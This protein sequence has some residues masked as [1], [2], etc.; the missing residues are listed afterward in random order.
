MAKRGGSRRRENVDKRRSG[1]RRRSG[2]D[3]FV[4]VET[5]EKG[6]IIHAFSEKNCPGLLVSI[7][8][9]F[10]ELDLELSDATVSCSDCFRLEAVSDVANGGLPY[11]GSSP[12]LELSSFDSVTETVGCIHLTDI[13]HTKL[14]GVQPVTPA[15]RVSVPHHCSEDRL[16][17][18]RLIRN[19]EWCD[20]ELSHC[21]LVCDLEV[22]RKRHYRGTTL[23]IDNCYLSY[24]RDTLKA[25]DSREWD[26]NYKKVKDLVVNGQWNDV[27]LA[28]LFT[29]DI[30]EHIKQKLF[31]GP[32]ISQSPSLP[33]L[34]RYEATVKV[35][36]LLMVDMATKNHTRPSCARVKIEIDLITKLPHRVKINEKD[37]ITGELKSKWIQ[38][39]YDHK[40]KYCNECCLQGHDKE[41]CWNI[42]H[43][44]YAKSQEQRHEKDR[45]NEDEKRPKEMDR[46]AT[47]DSNKYQWLQ[48]R[49]KYRRDRF[50]HI[51]ERN[52]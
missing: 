15:G 23:K 31:A 34:Q 48:R 2:H 41:S 26:D 10:E 45:T 33:Q 19:T 43:E 20:G 7:L 30:V 32:S 22:W 38:I 12:F 44:I 11:S 35:G 37:D 21:H 16:N 9:A 52:G 3:G 51:L 39:Q 4:T 25:Q 5:L 50:G 40:P 46:S 1:G 14:T 28:E 6:F 13:P 47:T 8:E 49:N 18:L 36:K 24:L 17:I 27:V 29:D 42:H